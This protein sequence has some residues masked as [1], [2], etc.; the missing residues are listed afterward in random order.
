MVNLLIIDILF[1]FIFNIYL[2]LRERKSM[3]AQVGEVQRERGGTE[4]PRQALC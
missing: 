3:H 2:F 1:Y 4:D